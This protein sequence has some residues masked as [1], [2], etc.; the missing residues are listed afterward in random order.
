MTELKP[1]PFCG[2]TPTI[3][4]GA[5][6]KKYWISCTNDKCACAPCTYAHVNKGVVVRAWNSRDNDA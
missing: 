1:C 3:E 2:K 6:I 5:S 4:Y